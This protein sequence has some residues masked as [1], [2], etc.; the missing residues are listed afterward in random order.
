MT[1]LL[2]T[3][4]LSLFLNQLL[5]ASPQLPDYIIYKGDTIST[6]NLI[7]EE[8]LQKKNPNEDKL[9]GLSFRN[10]LSEDAD[11]NMG[12]SFNC[13]RGYQAIYEIE[14]DSLFLSGIIRCHSLKE[15]N[16]EFSNKA[17]HALFGNQVKNN[18]VFIDWFSGDISF[19]TKS[20]NN[21]N[22]VIR[23][24]GVFEKIF[25][26]ETLIKIDKG[27][28]KYAKEI[29]NYVSISNRID[30]KERDSIIT[31]LFDKIKNRKWEKLNK[32]DCSETY[33]I[34]INK[35]GKIDLVEMRLTKEEINDFFEKEEYQYCIC[36]MKK[37][38]MGLKF[39]I[40]KRKGQIGRA[41]V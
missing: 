8:Y 9:F 22:E 37:A 32:F 18:K 40:I 38:L 6:Y 26:F 31:I 10:F 34:R 36:S 27:I 1:K 39:D 7:L 3:I 4:L 14:N 23:W 5:V 13:W 29:Q 41:H 19:P 30:R 35:K 25:L 11:L 16:K 20:K 28:I 33:I 12:A 21:Q 15:M 2:F 24:D 17:L